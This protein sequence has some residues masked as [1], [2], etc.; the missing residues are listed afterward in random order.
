MK[1]LQFISKIV[2]ILVMLNG[3]EESSLIPSLQISVAMHVFGV[4]DAG[5]I[6]IRWVFGLMEVIGYEEALRASRYIEPAEHWILY[7]WW[8]HVGAVLSG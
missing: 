3:S 7:D 1:L 5:W 2:L 6:M 4:M 8:P